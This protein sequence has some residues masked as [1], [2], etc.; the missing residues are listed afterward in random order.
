MSLERLVQLRHGLHRDP[1]LS[2]EEHRTAE[3]IL[4][5]FKPLG[6]DNLIRGLG[7]HGLAFVFEGARSGPTVLLRCDMDALPIDERNEHAY[8]SRHPGIGHQCGHDGHM[9]VLAAVGASLASRRPDSGRV[10]LLYQPAEETGSGAA[11][12]IADPRFE[13]IEPDLAFALHNLPG[14]PLGQVVVRNGTFSCA[15]R[16]MSITLRGRTAHAAQPETGLS[17]AT[18]MCELIAGLNSLPSGVVPRGELGFATVVGASLGRKAFGTAPGKAELWTTL[19]SESNAGMDSMVEYA[20]R[21][22]QMIAREHDLQL[23]YAYQDIFPATVN[24]ARAVA[25]VRGA[26]NAAGLL[27]PD[28]PFRWSEDFG[29]ICARCDAAM[30][31][32]GAGETIADLHNPD[33]DFPDAL[34][35][36]ARDCFLDIVAACT[37]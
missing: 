14:Y 11:A 36:P 2:G 10:V 37:G 19:R 8:C 7:G 31:G 26:A 9:A 1:E 18:A 30:F 3:T 25:I 4:E 16:G 15:S 13:Q 29:H 5:F 35:E 6:P 20:E 32:I 34:I 33:Y 22:A 28:A 27:E 23:E 12:V 17:P 24:S 21:L